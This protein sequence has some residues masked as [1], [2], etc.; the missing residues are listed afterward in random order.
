MY[1]RY[2]WSPNC[3]PAQGYGM[4]LRVISRRFLQLQ[5]LLPLILVVGCNMFLAAR[6]D[7]F[8]SFADAENDVLYI[9]KR[10][11]KR[12]AMLHACVKIPCY[13]TRV[14]I[15]DALFN[16]SGMWRIYIKYMQCLGTGAGSA[17][18][19]VRFMLRHSDEEHTKKCNPAHA[20]HKK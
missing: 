4:Y 19:C 18:V 13:N 8:D 6:A 20:C 16:H 1:V 12:D 9:Q 3:R 10:T 2:W 7:R 5:V 17:G 14:C 15:C 11:W